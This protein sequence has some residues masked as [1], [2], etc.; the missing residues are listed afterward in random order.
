[1]FQTSWHYAPA[2]EVVSR[3]GI[4]LVIRSDKVSLF[5]ANID[6]LQSTRGR[7]RL[8]PRASLNV[9]RVNRRNVHA[10][11]FFYRPEIVVLG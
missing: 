4:V 7:R 9:Q 5:E 8:P 11:V 1:V 10:V 2:S 3:L 6:G